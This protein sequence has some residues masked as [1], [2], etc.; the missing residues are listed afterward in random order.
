MLQKSTSILWLHNINLTFVLPFILI[1]ATVLLLIKVIWN[2]S[3]Y[4][5]GAGGWLFRGLCSLPRC[6]QGP[7]RP[8]SN[9]RR[10]QLGPTWQRARHRLILNFT[11]NLPLRSGLG[12]P[13]FTTTYGLSLSSSPLCFSLLLLFCLL[14]S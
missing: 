9:P 13:L 14:T 7:G 12:N 2:A 5:P 3:I 11:T 1:R 4:G 6:T 10:A 8:P